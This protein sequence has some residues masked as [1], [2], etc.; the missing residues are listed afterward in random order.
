[1]ALVF[2]Q[3]LFCSSGL[4]GTRQTESDLTKNI[5]TGVKSR[6]K[7]TNFKVDYTPFAAHK[8]D[9]RSKIST[10]SVVW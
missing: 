2:G 9:A 10:G 6:S 3:P 5:E 1:M 4:R 7:I 8:S